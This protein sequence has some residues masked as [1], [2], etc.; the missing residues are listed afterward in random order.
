MPSVYESYVV[1]EV[2]PVPVQTSHAVVHPVVP[3]VR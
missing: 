1:P 3:D 2:H